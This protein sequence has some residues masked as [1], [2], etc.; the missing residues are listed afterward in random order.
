MSRPS[1]LADFDVVTGP[2]APARPIPAMPAPAANS[3]SPE[4]KRKGGG[5]RNGDKV[6]LPGA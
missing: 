1:S 6:T 3:V 4:P 5:S 2:A